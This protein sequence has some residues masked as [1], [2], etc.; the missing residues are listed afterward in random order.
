MGR[1]IFSKTLD[2][3]ESLWPNEEL[4]KKLYQLELEWALFTDEKENDIGKLYK[5]LTE[6]VCQHVSTVVDWV[7]DELH[8]CD[9]WWQPWLSSVDIYQPA[10]VRRFSMRSGG[11]YLSTCSVCVVFACVGRVCTVDKISTSTFASW[12]SR[13]L[14]IVMKSHIWQIC[15]IL[16]LL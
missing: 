5:E 15:F 3:N 16:H 9:L 8:S 2:V 6:I 1:Y 11:W 14:Y 13:D 10:L 4:V 12:I 7:K